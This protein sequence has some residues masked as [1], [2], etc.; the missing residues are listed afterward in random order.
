MSTSLRLPITIA[1]FLCCVLAGCESRE[2]R[3]RREIEAR[4]AENSAAFKAKDTTA[5]YVLRAD[6]FHTETPDGLTHSFDDM[7][8]YTRRLFDMIAQ[9]D[10]IAFRIDS[11][12]FRGDTVVAV[13]FQY[14]ERLQHLPPDSALHHV[15]MSVVQREQWVPSDR[16]WLL[17][18]V[19]EIRDQQRWIDGVLQPPR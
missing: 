9:F 6:A 4:Y 5:V 15:T 13:A 8:A 12:G 14:T 1:A 2:A 17:W 10:S 18:R 16:G 19:D 3:V 7:R 11:L